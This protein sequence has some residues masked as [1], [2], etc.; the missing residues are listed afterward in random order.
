MTVLK[1]VRKTLGYAAV[2]LSLFFSLVGIDNSAAH[3]AMATV[4]SVTISETSAVLAIDSPDVAFDFYTL[5]APPRLV[6]DVSGVLP[7][8]EER[9]FD[10]ASGFS[11][12]RVGIY[13]DKTRF[14]FDANSGQLPE[15]TVERYGNDIVIDWSGK[16]AV[17]VKPR[18]EK[19][20][21]VKSINF[22]A[23]DGASTFTVDFDGRFDLIEAETVDGTIRFG[24]SD[25]VIPRSLRRVVDASVFPSS[26]LQIT[27]YSTIIDGTRNVMFS[28]KM[29][30]L[31]QYSV[32]RNGS[33][34]VF[35]TVDGVFAETAPS[36]LDS[37]YVPV[38]PTKAAQSNGIVETISD[39][40]YAYDENMDDVSQVLNRIEGESAAGLLSA[41]ADKDAPKVYTGEP[42]TLV[43]DDADIRKVMQLIA[44]ISNL[45]IILSDD[46]KG[47]VSLR[48]HDVPWDQ[49]LDLILDV[50]QLGT[51]T[52][53]NVVRIL[54]LGTI[55]KMEAERLKATKDIKK[56]EETRT[57]IFVIN[58]KDTEA[59]EDV[60]D[61]VLSNQGE[62]QLIEGS[63]KIMVNDIPSKLEEIR[64]LINQLDEPVKQVLIEARIVEAD[65]SAEQTFGI[66]WGFEF[67]ND[68]GSSGGG[69]GSSLD[70]AV[71]GLG[72]NFITPTS[73]TDGLGTALTFGRVGLDT[74]VLDLQ[75]S[76]LESS[77]GGKVISS[78]KV[79]ALD[80][81]T[82]RIGQGTEIPY[83]TTSDNGTTT[84]FKKAELALEVTPLINPDNT[85]LLEILATNSSPGVAYT[86]G[87][88]I[89]TK[90]AETKLLLKNGETTV[91]GG[92]YTE[93]EQNSDSGT[94]YL[95]DLPFI[96]NL[97]K[98]KTSSN[99]RTEL[100][101]FLTPHIVD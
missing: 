22:D 96:G 65:T 90:E 4:E 64:M 2:V 43:L 42:V 73:A 70:N 101:I 21:S 77:G 94:P 31:V 83:K 7:L 37:V 58:Y 34:L 95:K 27:P 53:G 52:Q 75:L 46:V 84:E 76:A 92:I 54:P 72:G 79:M 29:K 38:Q 93:N 10:V 91:I 24:A 47:K 50:K 17:A 68:S 81:E 12:I 57:E 6:V 16:T 60:I 8:F 40:A 66:H 97:F 5:G 88:A 15:A 59:I 78:P 41:T 1:P 35:S 13:A 23:Q 74:I 18:V 9:A 98:Y 11:A 55:K 63:K 51:I 87:V 56:L 30:G 32:S 82:A 67:D 33:Q 85:I 36:A 71:V 39:P 99:D 48:L 20:V 89:N 69:I 100:L 80:G 61:D 45:N 19:P 25:T 44:E 26:V 86:D 28:A 49:A 62:V 14:V 3:A